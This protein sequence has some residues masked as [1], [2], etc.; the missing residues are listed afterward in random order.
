MDWD[1]GWDFGWVFIGLGLQ[2]SGL[3]FLIVES[4]IRRLDNPAWL[5]TLVLGFV[6]LSVSYLIGAWPR[7]KPA[8]G[9]AKAVQ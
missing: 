4:I 6:M 3:Y 9:S 8:G 5:T 7:R 2:V 1:H